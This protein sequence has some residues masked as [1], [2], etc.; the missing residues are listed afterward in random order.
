MPHALLTFILAIVAG[1]LWFSEI[2]Y[3]IGW[4]GRQWL[5]HTHYSIFVI[6]AIVLLTYCLPFWRSPLTTISLQRKMGAFLALYGT[7]LFAYY[8][9]KQLFFGS[10]WSPISALTMLSVLLI[11]V[12]IIIYSISNKWLHPIKKR[13]IPLFSFVFILTMIMTIVM[14][15][16]WA[17]IWFDFDFDLVEN[18]K[19]GYPYF[20]ITIF[21]GITGN[22][23]VNYL[24]TGVEQQIHNSYDEILDA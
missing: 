24:L 6:N 5:D 7:T 13:Q 11:L 16:I 1:L 22:G 9:G 15:D 3:W 19:T 23:S 21:M 4:S 2:N 18:I 14:P 17:G 8:T 12:P 20:W 10:F